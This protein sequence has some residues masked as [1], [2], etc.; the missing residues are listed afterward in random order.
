[1]RVTIYW[2]TKDGG[3]IDRIRKRFGI[4]SGITINGETVAEVDSR[5]MD[6]L[7]EYERQG[8]I[9]LRYKNK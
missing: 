1:M 2:R 9:Q 4:S 6:E 8:F 3:L 5:Q 7:R